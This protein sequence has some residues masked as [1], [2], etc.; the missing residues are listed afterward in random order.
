MGIALRMRYRYTLVDVL[1]W[2]SGGRIELEREA[3]HGEVP[4]Y[5]TDRQEGTTEVPQGEASCQEGQK[6]R[7]ILM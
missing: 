2:S 1:G 5:K 4:G 3:N 7:E 6:G